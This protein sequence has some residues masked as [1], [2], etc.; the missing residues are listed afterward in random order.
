MVQSPV[1][2]QTFRHNETGMV[3][4]RAVTLPGFIVFGDSEDELEAKVVPAFESFLEAAQLHDGRHWKLK[5]ETVPGFSPPS[6]S[7]LEAA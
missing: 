3:M 1:Q 5:T 6:Y 7:L 4:M 2:L